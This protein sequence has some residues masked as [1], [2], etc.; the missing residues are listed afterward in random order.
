[1][2]AHLH[3]VYLQ[4]CGSKR[5]DKHA[6]FVMGSCS[7]PVIDHHRKPHEN[8]SNEPSDPNANLIPAGEPAY[9]TIPLGVKSTEHDVQRVNAQ[10]TMLS[11]ETDIHLMLG[12]LYWKCTV[13]TM[14][15]D[16]VTI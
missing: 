8:Y 5:E 4:D 13:C 12:G 3:C 2:C 9:L 15:D 6:S 1:M 16:K 11:L 14:L 7:A 10:S